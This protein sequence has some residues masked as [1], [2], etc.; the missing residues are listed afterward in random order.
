MSTVTTQLSRDHPISVELP[1]PSK[2]HSGMN[3]N[4]FIWRFTMRSLVLVGFKADLF[5]FP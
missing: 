5:L 2:F 3:M 4:M 1:K